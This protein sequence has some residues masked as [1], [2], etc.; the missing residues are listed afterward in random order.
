MARRRYVRLNLSPLKRFTRSLQRTRS[1]DLDAMYK[2]WAARYLGFAQRRFARQSRGGGEWPRLA[3]STV[4]KRR[5]GGRSRGGSNQ[6]ATNPR[7][8]GGRVAILRDTGTLYGALDI[9]AR[10]NTRR[11]N[12]GIR[13]GFMGQQPHGNSRITIAHLAAIH[14]FGRG[15]VPKR[16][17]IVE[18]DRPTI[19]GMRRDLR[20]A[21]RGALRKYS[22]RT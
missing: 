22:R 8:T 10:S 17:I 20:L 14:Q 11:I 15:R 19:E 4:Q 1:S 16:P 18:P 6:V 2:R 5:R 21:I 7:A 13:V 9:G 3:Q 12:N